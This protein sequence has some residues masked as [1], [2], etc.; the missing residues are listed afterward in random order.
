MM[1]AI[2]KMW[3]V[4]WVRNFQGVCRVGRGDGSIVAVV[5]ELVDELLVY[6]ECIRGKATM[7]L[8]KVIQ[9]QIRSVLRRP[10]LSIRAGVRKG[11]AVPTMFLAARVTL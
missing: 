11:V 7:P 10:T 8:R 3:K 2:L 5:L 4:G 9:P 6:R 1:L